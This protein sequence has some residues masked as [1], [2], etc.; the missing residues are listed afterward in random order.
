MA[1]I[2]TPKQAA[3]YTGYAP[4]TLAGWC[5]ES[6]GRLKFGLP[7]LGPRWVDGPTGRRRGYTQ[8]ALDEWLAQQEAA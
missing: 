3:E 8:E 4:D 5:Y 2:L 1:K 6:R 7:I